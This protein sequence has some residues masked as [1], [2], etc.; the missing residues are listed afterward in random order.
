MTVLVVGAST[1]FGA[2]IADAFV[3]RGERVI[4]TSRSAPGEGAL[5]TTGLTMAQLDVCD[6]ASVA[7]LAARL[8][9]A[10]IV[11]DVAVLNAGYGIS[12]AI[13]DTPVEAA[14]AQFNTN[15][16]G[17][18]RMVRALLP[19]MRARGSGQLIVIGSVAAQIPVPF[20]AFYSASKAAVEAYAAAL[21]MEV[22]TFGIEAT[23]VEPG[24]HKTAF[25]AARPLSDSGPESAYQPQAQRAVAIMEASELAGAPASD[26][27]RLVVRI[28]GLK[29]PKARY[30][31]ANRMERLGLVLQRVLPAALFEG[32]IMDTYKVPGR[33]RRTGN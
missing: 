12:G 17:V 13:E 33:G 27:A 29:R 11:P 20:Q 3:A 22:A 18:H 31:Q 9:K 30:V 21:R 5:A 19:G 28:A 4:G 23:V 25:G 16:L 7:A 26:V 1:G 15:F 6:E 24:D 14:M 32:I 8:D 2:A 10:G